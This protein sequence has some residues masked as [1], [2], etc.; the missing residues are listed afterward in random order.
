MIKTVE[1]YK[2]IN[3]SE[4]HLSAVSCTH[5]KCVNHYTADRVLEPNA[6]TLRFNSLSAN[7]EAVG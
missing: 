3:H 7:Q 5:G 2:K 1:R 4:F 6:V